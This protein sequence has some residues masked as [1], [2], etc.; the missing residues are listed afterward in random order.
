MS[1]PPRRNTLPPRA[2]I[3][4]GS[5]FR[6]IFDLRRRASDRLL[7]LYM[8]PNN[9]GFNRLGMAVSRHFGNAVRRNRVK[10]LIREAFRHLRHELPGPADWV[11]IPKPGQ[12]PGLS[13]LKH[14]IRKLARHLGK[15][16]R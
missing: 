5:D 12:S 11:I 13:D 9:C 16:E 1:E 8:A 7:T 3:R 14:S 2:R 10:R 4:S 15:K 6:R